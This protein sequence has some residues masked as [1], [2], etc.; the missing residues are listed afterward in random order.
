MVAMASGVS[1]RLFVS[2]SLA[3]LVGAAALTIPASGCSVFEPP[4][5]ETRTSQLAHVVGSAI[6]VE[7][8][9]G[10]ISVET[11]DQAKEVTVVAKLKGTSKERLD[12]TKVLAERKP[13]NSLSIYVKWPNDSRDGGEGCS[14]EIKLPDVNGATLKS[15]NGA[16]TLVGA[17]GDA[18]LKSSNGA[19]KVSRH[20]GELKVK[21]SNGAITAEGINGPAELDTSNGAITLTL[22]AAA[23]GQ[24]HLDTSNGAITLAV[25]K[26]FAGELSAKTS[27]GSVAVPE[28][29][30]VKVLSKDKHHAKVSFG[31]GGKDSKVTSSNGSITIRRAE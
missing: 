23:A 6:S 28:G 24:V 14:F 20:T 10:A 5:E 30:G 13:D 2:G 31:D 25:G 11:S 9:N 26:A 4:V 3:A 12:A 17:S 19:V 29:A 22:T 8:A 15:S 27:N 1:R 7:T 18:S 21:T 16:L